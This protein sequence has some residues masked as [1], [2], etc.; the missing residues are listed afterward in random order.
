MIQRISDYL[1]TNG[2]GSPV[3][4][5]IGVAFSGG[6]DSTALLCALKELGATCVA[7]HCNFHLRGEESDRDERHARLT[8]EKLGVPIE[9]IHFD[10]DARKTATGE[11]TEMACRELRYRWFAEMRHKLQLDFIALGHHLEDNIE[12]MLLNL[13]RGSGLKGTAGIRPVRDFYLRPLLQTSREELL[14]YL[15]ARGLGFVV[16]STNLQNDYKRNRLRNIVLPKLYDAFPEAA[17][18]FSK[19]LSNLDS[20]RSLFEALI[21]QKRDLYVDAEGKVDVASIKR[22]EPC[23][24]TLLFH[25]LNRFSHDTAKEIFSKAESSGLHFIDNDGNS[26]LLNRGVLIPVL[27]GESE[28]Q[29]ATIDLSELNN[30]AATR[31]TFRLP[32]NSTLTAEILPKECFKPERNHNTLWLDTSALES[33]RKKERNPLFEL[34]HPATGDRIKPFGMKGSRLLSD[35]FSDAKLSE[36]E[37]RMQWVLTR[38][39]EILWVIGHKASRNFPVLESTEKVIRLSFNKDSK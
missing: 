36:I 27:S 10:V 3:G 7:L 14:S 38:E 1:K 16:D 29:T 31:L 19:S 32:D 17:S 37:K 21:A 28:A 33:H 39:D 26:Y 2:V 11:S 25:I 13:L 23:G 35:V 4:K 24:E 9:V 15:A 5:R 6:A 18:G 12:T 22:T 30:D 20:D 8:A 34:R